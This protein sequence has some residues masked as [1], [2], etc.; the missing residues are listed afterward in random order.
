MSLLKEFPILVLVKSVS[1]LVCV[2]VCWLA[3]GLRIGRGASL[4]LTLLTYP[5]TLSFLFDLSNSHKHS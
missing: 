1:Q 2:C 5:T 3:A 4:L